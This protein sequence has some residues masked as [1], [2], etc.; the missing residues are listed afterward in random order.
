MALIYG[1][2]NHPTDS[3]SEAL[4][5]TYSEMGCHRI[6]L[7]SVILSERGRDWGPE[8]DCTITMCDIMTRRWLLLL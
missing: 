4:I 1:R 6:H 7:I 3:P 5:L 8:N 2:I